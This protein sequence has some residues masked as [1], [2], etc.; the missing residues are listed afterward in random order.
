MYHTIPAVVQAWLRFP[1][2]Y[3]A[4]VT[5]LIECGGDTDTTAA[6]AG[7]IVGARVGKAGI[8]AAWL[9]GLWEWPR[10][11]AWME[12]LGER[13]AEVCRRVTPM[14][15]PRLSAPGLLARNLCSWPS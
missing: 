1:S 9:A 13:L 11:V 15:A 3:R 14:P 6:I 4:A 8:P 2:D 7:G 5:A 10:T 12:R